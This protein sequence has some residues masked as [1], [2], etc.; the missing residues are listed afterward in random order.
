VDFGDLSQYVSFEQNRWSFEALP[1]LHKLGYTGFKLI[2]QVNYLA[3]EYPP[4]KEERFHQKIHTVLQSRSFFLRA[5]RKLGVRQLLESQV[6]R[7]RRRNGWRFPSGSSG[8]FAENTP[9]R[10]QNIDEIMSAFQRTWDASG[11]GK[12]SIF[13]GSESPGFWADFHARREG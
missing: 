4:T 13:W 8:P 6:D 10:W 9:G 12:P 3:V 5:A 2:S 7:T 1:L 11:A